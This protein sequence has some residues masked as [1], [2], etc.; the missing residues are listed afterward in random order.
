[1]HHP[2]PPRFV[3]VGDTVELAPRNPDPNAVYTWTVARA[4]KKST[5]TVGDAPVAEFVPDVAGLYRVQL[6]AP[7]GVHS[8]TVRAFGEVPTRTHSG[9]SG[10]S[11]DTQSTEDSEASM[12]DDTTTAKDD[13][14]E[15]TGPAPGGRPR[16]RL[17]TVRRSGG[18]VVTADPQPHPDGDE[19]TADL[20]V[21]FLLDDRDALGWSDVRVH[22]TELVIPRNRLPERVRVYAV[23]L[24]GGGYS[25]PDA[26]EITRD[27][28]PPGT[29]SPDESGGVEVRTA[30]PFDPPEW[31]EDAV[32]YEIHVRTFP[33]QTAGDDDTPASDRSTF[34]A[35]IDRLDYIK[36]LGVDVLWLT[37]VLQNDHAAHGYNVTDF[38]SIAEDLG[39]RADYKRMIRAAHERDIRVLFDFVANHSAREHP[40]F[41]TAVADPDSEYR[42]WYEWREPGEPE[43]YFDW[44]HIAN[45][46]FTHLPVRRHL[47]DAVDEW[48][49]LVDGFR[50]DMAWAVPNG[51]WREIHDRLKARDREFLLLDET[52]PYIPDFQAG[53]FDIHFDSTTYAALR[54]VGNGEAPAEA[55]L[56]AIEDRSRSGFPDFAGFM[57][58]AE[59][60]D[61]TRY[62][63]ECGR[64]AARAALGALFT[65]P[66][67]P[68]VYA[69]QEFGQRGTRDDL[70]WEHVDEDLQ[71]YVE[72]LTTARA[73]H[74]ALEARADLRR[75]DYEVTQ[76]DSD[77]V[78]MFSRVADI[79]SEPSP[80]VIV[81]LN[82]GSQQAKVSVDA[83]TEET[84]VVT[85][86]VVSTADGLRVDDVVVV[87]TNPSQDGLDD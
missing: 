56:D 45:F 5:A 6:S 87:Q 27:E 37:P 19:T 42:D 36:G 20:D 16:V 21:E 70:A 47:L 25:V 61:E 62:I 29:G 22:G 66:G 84:D 68:M 23:A 79:D 50:C 46:D 60:H 1:M 76:G 48:S 53:L 10:A 58:Y 65:L 13:K 78:V 52:I 15:M 7:D 67:A 38:F 17:S 35:I 63:T 14:T 69:G 72:R 32:I 4:P 44:E 39:T 75:I 73:S 49:A 18:V 85:N 82:F 3:T 12:T 9:R 64:P 26:V 34:D 55:L 43:T 2:G 40:Y 77:R 33:G 28:T 86:E 54:R 80:T 31:A 41:K 74:P 51:F 83:T 81:G 57:L 8:L 24:G 11:G 30:R 71:Q 59:N